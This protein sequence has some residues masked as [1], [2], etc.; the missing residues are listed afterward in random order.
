[1]GNDEIHSQV[2]T[3]DGYSYQDMFLGKI[4][5]E[6][7]NT[8]LYYVIQ[9]AICQFAA[10]KSPV[11]WIKGARTSDDPFLMILLR[12]NP[13]FFQSLSIMFLFYF[14]ARYHFFM[15]GVYSILVFVLT[16][17]HNWVCWA[18]ARPYALW[19]FLTFAQVLLFLRILDLT[20]VKIKHFLWLTVI[21]LLLSLTVVLSLGQI[22][23]VSVLLWIFKDRKLSKYVF[24]TIVPAILCFYYY[25]RTIKDR[26]S[27]PFS[28]PH[29]IFAHIPAPHWILI[30]VFL[31]LALVFW[32][33]L[34]INKKK[35]FCDSMNCV[36]LWRA[37]AIY[38]GLMFLMVLVS[39]V[40]F[41]LF[42]FWS[43]HGVAGNKIATRYWLFLTPI[44]I[45]G[46]VLIVSN[47]FKVFH[48]QYWMRINLIIL[49]L[50][51][52]SLCYLDN[53]PLWAYLEFLKRHFGILS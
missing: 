49:A 29:V 12:L 53:Y 23:A 42:T 41:T 7:N 13:I 52:L 25:S 47:L 45:V 28:F 8:P 43:S 36:R 6:G 44:G 27:V 48:E 14:F 38:V 50:G 46:V 3:I 10:V 2:H 40:V 37:T 22:G 18:E 26:Y 21:H 16:S 11:E 15:A 4:G 51:T 32:I 34:M 33:Q 1:M 24:L 20:E 39:A 5:G 35:I 17:T 30:I 9:K 19:T 31:V